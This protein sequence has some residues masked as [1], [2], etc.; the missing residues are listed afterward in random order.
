MLAKKLDRECHD[1]A[2]VEGISTEKQAG[3]GRD[4]IRRE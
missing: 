1:D 2:I 4:K 3:V